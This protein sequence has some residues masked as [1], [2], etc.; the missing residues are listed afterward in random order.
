M[1][2]HR[3]DELTPWFVG[4]AVPA[5]PGVYERSYVNYGPDRG[6]KAYAYWNGRDWFVGDSA[7]DR[8]MQRAAN[9]DNASIVQCLPWRG[10]REAAK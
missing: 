8:A 5:R 4:S 9:P 7:P 10:L 1:T 6:F 3:N 2:R